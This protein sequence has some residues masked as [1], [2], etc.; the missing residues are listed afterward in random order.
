MKSY[1]KE[2][3]FEVP[4]RRQ[5]VHITPAIEQCLQESGIREGLLLCNAMHLL[6]VFSSMIMNQVYIA[7]SKPGLKN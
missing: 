7:I 6:P 3:W 5:F 1:R 4:I 2:L